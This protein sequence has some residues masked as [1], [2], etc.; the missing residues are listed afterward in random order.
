MEEEKTESLFVCPHG[1]CVFFMSYS[2]LMLV[3]TYHKSKLSVQS[4]AIC[5]ILSGNT[6]GQMLCLKHL[7]QFQVF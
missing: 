3:N 5:G 6:G 2:L 4:N 1:K 7:Q